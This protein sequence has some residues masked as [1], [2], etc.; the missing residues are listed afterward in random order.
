M[1]ARVIGVGWMEDEHDA[2]RINEQS[3]SEGQ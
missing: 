1:N 3:P 2:A